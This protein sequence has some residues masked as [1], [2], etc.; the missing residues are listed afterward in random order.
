MHVKEDAVGFEMTSAGGLFPA[1]A[2]LPQ[3][4][5]ALLGR[6]G[7]VLLLMKQNGL[8]DLP[9]GKVDGSESLDTALTREVEEETGLSV[10]SVNPF[11]RGLRHRDPR[12]PVLVTFYDVRTMKLWTTGDVR[13][14]GEHRDLVMAD[15]ALLQRLPM[16]D[17]YRQM[18]LNWLSRGA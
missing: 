15:A 7:M 2:E 14:S 13:L 3:T 8:W 5:K 10:R 12:V 11:S 9:G 1:A 17:V 4:V 16:P 6:D 18:G